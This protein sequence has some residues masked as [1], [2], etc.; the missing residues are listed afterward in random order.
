MESPL[1]LI[2]L[3]LPAIVPLCNAQATFR[4]AFLLHDYQD[5]EGKGHAGPAG[6]CCPYP[7]AGADALVYFD[8]RLATVLRHRASGERAART[9]YR[10]LL[11]LLGEKRSARDA[12][13]EAAAFLRLDAL[14]EIVPPR[15]RARIIEQG[16]ARIRNAAL[17]RWFGEAE[18]D[19][20]AAALARAALEDEEWAALIPELP[21]RARGFLRHRRD[22]PEKAVAILDRLGVRDRALP[23][24]EISGDPFDL[25]PFPLEE[26]VP[27]IQAPDRTA[28]DPDGAALPVPTPPAPPP[29]R[30]E[31]AGDAA[32]SGDEGQR[33]SEEG[34]VDPAPT[35]TE[36]PQ[37]PRHDPLVG[38]RPSSPP[39]D[40]GNLVKRIQAFS[41]ARAVPARHGDAPRLPLD[42]YV[43]EQEN[44][45]IIAFDFGT[46]TQGR[47]DWADPEIAPMVIGT[48][49]LRQVGEQWPGSMLAPAFLNRQPIRDA[50]LPLTG[51]AQIAGLWVVDAT[52]RFAASDGR[53]DGYVGRFR[54]AQSGDG[55]ADQSGEADRIRQLLH[56]L[57]TPVN[58]IQGFAE[59]IQQ[60]VFGPTPHEYRALA[61]SIAGDSAR[62][63]AGFD[64]LDRL[65]KLESGAMELDDGVTDFTGIA[66]QMV[67]Q[68]QSVLSPRVA[69]FEPSWPT[70]PLAI[71]LAQ[72]ETEMLA[73]RVFATVASATG[74]GEKLR[75]ALLH[76]EDRLLL[77][78]DL[79]A[80]LKSAEELFSTDTRPSG[81]ALS[82]GIFGA[83]FSL[84]LARAEAR[85]AG[86]ELERVDDQLVLALPLLTGVEAEPSPENTPDRAAG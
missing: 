33:A 37:G 49:V 42:D 53:F 12:S 34:P 84:R 32:P 9:Q 60:Q 86:G 22:L 24:P 70:A 75:L 45:S 61:A 29:V 71:A 81:G 78:C 65:A 68:L 1:F 31:N 43:R 5:M 50:R 62:M 17:V 2:L 55:A 40:I 18:P 16:G 20:A 76:D 80:T 4:S 35:P 66:Q 59:V 6:T 85:S 77:A 19:V 23:Q 67:E 8:D 11:D 36:P 46:D 82:P 44:P 28:S 10:Q 30:M 38:T 73:W 74:A 54:R 48:D 64:G 47:I 79:P 13:L 7:P 39:S 27:G 63:L 58:A 72:K 52:P 21:V 15:E 3:F 69:R 14:G 51:A 56:E 41:K 25:Q 57:R 26:E 83:G